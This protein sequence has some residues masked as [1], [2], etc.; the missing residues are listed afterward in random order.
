MKPSED[1]F[2]CPSSLVLFVAS[3]MNCFVRSGK[4]NRFNSAKAKNPPQPRAKHLKLYLFGASNNK[5]KKKMGVILKL[6]AK[7]MRKTN[8]Y[9]RCFKKQINARNNNIDSKIDTFPACI[10]MRMVE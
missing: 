7:T 5:I 6:A 9:R 2:K 3:E 8:E 4:R 1:G 10:S